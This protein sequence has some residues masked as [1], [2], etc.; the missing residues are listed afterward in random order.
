MKILAFIACLLLV[1][2]AEEGK[3]R[4]LEER[5]LQ[6]IPLTRDWSSV[7]PA[8]SLGTCKGGSFTM[9]MEMTLANAIVTVIES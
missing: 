9:K 6:G 4:D 8:K 3:R 5:N 2:L 7:I 1:T